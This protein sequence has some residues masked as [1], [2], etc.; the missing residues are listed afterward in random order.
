[1]NKICLHFYQARSVVSV[2]LHYS[3]HVFKVAILVIVAVSVLTF[4]LEGLS[5]VTDYYLSRDYKYLLSSIVSSALAICVL[6]LVF[7]GG[8]NLLISFS[9]C[10][11]NNIKIKDFYSKT[12]LEILE[13]WKNK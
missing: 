5:G 7:L 10:K 13:I 6:V 8:I 4:F 1:M 9:Y 11:K 2:A 3:L 12:N